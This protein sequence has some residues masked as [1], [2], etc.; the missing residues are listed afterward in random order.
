MPEPVS[1]TRRNAYDESARVATPVEIV[2]LPP[3]G[4]ASRALT[5]RLSSAW[6]S[7]VGSTD[8]KHA[9]SA[10]SVTSSTSAPISRRSIGCAEATTSFRSTISLIRASLRLKES[11]RC[12]RSRAFAA[13]KAICSSSWRSSA[14]SPARSRASS[15]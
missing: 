7:S 8:T 4:I 10:G 13:A 12:V 9:C 2:S 3:A 14:S 5:A 6:S 11:R 15:P 1:A